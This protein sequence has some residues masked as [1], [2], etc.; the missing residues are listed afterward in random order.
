MILIQDEMAQKRRRRD[1]I[2]AQ[3]LTTCQGS[4][5]S[6]TKVVY[7]TNLNFKT[8][9]LHLDLLIANG[10]LEATEGP[11]I[12]YVTTEKGEQMI[13]HLKEIERLMPLTSPPARKINHETG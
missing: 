3:I 13:E 8:V 11:I 12:M 10:L 2:V 9:N 7:S 6:K 5:A 4:G 1:Q